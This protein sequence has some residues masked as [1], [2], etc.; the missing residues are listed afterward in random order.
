MIE[1]ESYSLDG[2]IK[3]IKTLLGEL[4]CIKTR[5]EKIGDLL[6]VAFYSKIKTLGE[7]KK[8]ASAENIIYSY[9]DIFGVDIE[10]KDM[11]KEYEK[12]SSK[13]LAITHN[14]N[15]KVLRSDWLNAALIV[16]S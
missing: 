4:L 13:K 10:I 9:I 2:N 8:F 15:E 3:A 7:S 11:M 5:T 14:E 6:R 16:E 1:C 12:I